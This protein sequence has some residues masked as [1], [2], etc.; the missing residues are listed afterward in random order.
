MD[1]SI[2]PTSDIIGRS[3]GSLSTIWTAVIVW[4]TD[5][6]ACNAFWE[7][8]YVLAVELVTAKRAAQLIQVKWLA[9]LNL[10]IYGYVY[11]KFILQSWFLHWVRQYNRL[12][13][14]K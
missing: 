5:A 1:F 9:K 7:A 14:W 2:G 13:P 10:L 6:G 12:A 8:I 4:S 3:E 11:M